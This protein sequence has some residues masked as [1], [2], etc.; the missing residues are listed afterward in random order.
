MNLITDGTTNQ[1]I[2]CNWK[3]WTDEELLLEY[4]YAA[5]N[6]FFGREAFGE[7][8]KR[9]ERELYNY[10]YRFLGNA[11]YAED[12]FQ[13]TFLAVLRECSKFDTGRTFRPWLYKI[14]TNQ[15]I[16]HQRKSKRYSVISIDEPQDRNHGN[17]CIADSLAENKPEPVEESMEQEMTC[18]VREAVAALPDKMKKAVYM[19]YFQG[20]THREA[21]KAVG[22]HNKTLSQW[23]GN[24][25]EKL[26]YLLKNAG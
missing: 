20:L 22:V 6:D 5:P 17:C 10:L 26:N 1:T 7:L 24:A 2:D 8:V 15:A 11:H 19:V 18:L 3:E 23:L 25:V 16:D 14:A 13:K 4:R 21:A 9:Y 12:V